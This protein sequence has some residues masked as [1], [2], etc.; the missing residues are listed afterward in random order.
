MACNIL[1]K[2]FHEDFLLFDLVIEFLPSWALFEVFL[3]CAYVRNCPP[4]PYGH[5]MNTLG[6]GPLGDVANQ[7][8]RVYAFKF[9]RRKFCSFHYL[10][11]CSNLWT[12]G[13]GQFWPQGHRVNKLGRGPLGDSTYQISKLYGF[14]FQRRRIL[15]ISFIVPMFELVAPRGGTSFIP[16][17][18]IW[19]NLVEVHF[20]MLHTKYQ[21]STTSS[22]IREDFQIF[23][24]FPVLL[25]WQPE[26]RVEFKFFD[27][28]GR[29]SPN[30]CLCYVSSRLAQWCRRRRYLKKLLT[31]NRRHK[32]GHRA[33]II[34][35][36]VTLH[37]GELKL[38]ERKSGISR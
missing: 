6:R 15:K 20:V 34:A 29:A 19:T 8:P 23:C 1:L 10:S 2:N 3:L 4:P 27:K 36:V 11:K 13:L 7:I 9:Q 14:Q 5:Y 21:R 22:F 38:I 25:P 12:P 18:I 16:R 32:A 28:Y 26:L 24:I 17:G 33:I 35:H 31:D 37:S 30:E